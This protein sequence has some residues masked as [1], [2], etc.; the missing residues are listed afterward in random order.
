MLLD[1]LASD[2]RL[3]GIERFTLAPDATSGVSIDL[4]AGR[5]VLK[6]GPGT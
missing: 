4:W 5:L 3:Y 1:D 6:D 2:S